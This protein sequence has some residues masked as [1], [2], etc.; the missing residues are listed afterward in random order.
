M[1]MLDE[2]A[3]NIPGILYSWYAGMEGGTAL[4]HILFGEFNP[5]GKLPFSIPAS[6]EHLPYFSSTDKEITYDLYH[7]YTLLDKN[8]HQ[9]AYPFGF[10]LS[11]TRFVYSDLSVFM[12]DDRL[13]VSVTV[14]NTGERDG[15]EAVQVYVGKP[16]SK[17]ERQRLPVYWSKRLPHHHPS[18][19]G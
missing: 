14:C 9:P 15:E 7:G 12:K 16:D 13:E 3:K 17:V 10:G 8:G 5:S 19:S 18:L 6:V 4:A 11:Y 1:I 2:W